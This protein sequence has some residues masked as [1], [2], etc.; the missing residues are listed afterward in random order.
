[1]ICANQ[2]HQKRAP[3][4]QLP[5]LPW[6]DLPALPLLKLPTDSPVQQL[7]EKQL[8]ACVIESAA[9]GRFNHIDAMI[10]MAAAGVGGAIIPAFAWQKCC[11]YDVAGAVL[12]NPITTMD[13]YLITARGRLPSDS[14]IELADM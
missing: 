8:Q 1:Y 7:V 13:F 2:E 5:T 6:R 9:H 3:L 11:H 12:V 14:V 10:A 4:S